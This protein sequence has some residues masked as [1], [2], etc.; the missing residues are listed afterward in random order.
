MKLGPHAKCSLCNA[1]RSTTAASE[2][3]GPLMNVVSATMAGGDMC[4]HRDTWHRGP[5]RGL[6]SFLRDLVPRGAVF[7]P[8]DLGAALMLGNC[9]SP[10]SPTFHGPG[11]SKGGRTRL[12]PAPGMG[13]A[14]E[15]WKLGPSCSEHPVDATEKNTGN[16]TWWYFVHQCLWHTSS[17]NVGRCVRSLQ[18]SRTPH[19]H[20]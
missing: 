18:S 8:R 20:V 13:T 6:C 5:S 2:R 10:W 7:S 3:K 12:S 16:H 11:P 15:A 4:H 14:P 19:S 1:S 17:F 9:K